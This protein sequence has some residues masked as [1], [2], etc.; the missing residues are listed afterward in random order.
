VSQ[1][2]A[3][4]PERLTWAV[5]MIAVQPNQRILEIGG[6]G[7]VAAA[8]VCDR[9]TRGSLLGLDRSAKAVAAAAQRNREAVAHGT[10]EFRSLALEDADPDVLGRFD[11]VFAVNVNLFWVG[12]AQKELGLIAR[13][14]RPAGKLWL[15]YE[16]PSAAG[17][18]RL[19]GRLVERLHAAGYRYRVITRP[20]ARA[21]LFAVSA[22]PSP[23]AAAAEAR[24]Y[25]DRRKRSDQPDGALGR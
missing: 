6:G 9:L 11:T 8:L 3:G 20:S 15:F 12:P 13:M 21:T 5:D 23:A 24:Q 16:P 19:R 14:L 7:G 25:R 1:G 10:A 22:Q 2:R 17:V 4:T 18:A